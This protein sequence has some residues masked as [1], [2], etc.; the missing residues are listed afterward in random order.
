MIGRAILFKMVGKK[1][2]ALAVVF[3]VVVI[4]VPYVFSEEINP[5]EYIRI[6]ESMALNFPLLWN[7]YLDVVNRAIQELSKEEKEE[8]RDD[9]GMEEVRMSVVVL[10]PNGTEVPATLVAVD[11]V[12]CTMVGGYISSEEAREWDNVLNIVSNYSGGENK[13]VVEEMVGL[14]EGL[15]AI[16]ESATSE[17][18]MLANILEQND[19]NVTSEN[20]DSLKSLNITSVQVRRVGGSGLIPGIAGVFGGSSRKPCPAATP[21][22]FGGTI[23]PNDDI[24]RPDCVLRPSVDNSGGLSGSPDHDADPNSATP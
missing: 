13:S 10:H 24:V 15:E 16:N 9:V 14:T 19:F 11:G 20:I 4:I 23:G 18:Y 5:E 8:L 6:D 2:W 1:F 7:H 3:L 22:V 21:G 12:C 17:N